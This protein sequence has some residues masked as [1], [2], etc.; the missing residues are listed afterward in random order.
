M[1]GGGQLRTLS[2]GPWA[3]LPAGHDA[4]EWHAEMAGGRTQNL[5][6]G[7]YVAR[8][9]EDDPCKGMPK[10]AGGTNANPLYGAVGGAFWWARTA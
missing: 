7:P 10:W 9:M 5:R 6:P 8:L 2:L 4:C 3:E 1:G